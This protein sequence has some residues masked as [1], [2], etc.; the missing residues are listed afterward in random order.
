MFV[1]PP[2]C[3]PLYSSAASDVFKG[4]GLC[5]VGLGLY[6]VCFVRCVGLGLC[7]VC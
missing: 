3:T 7:V 5:F 2:K 6:V 4:Q 1:R